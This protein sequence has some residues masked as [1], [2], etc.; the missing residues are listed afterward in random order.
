VGGCQRRIWLPRPILRT[1]ALSSAAHSRPEIGA[2]SLHDY[3]ATPAKTIMIQ[4]SIE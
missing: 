3:R 4:G 1:V 2:L